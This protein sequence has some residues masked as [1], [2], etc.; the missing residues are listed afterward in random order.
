MNKLTF[1]IILIYCL[2]LCIS[3]I[4]IPETPMSKDNPNDIKALKEIQKETWLEE[5]FITDADVLY[6]SMRANGKPQI[7]Y[8]RYLCTTLYQHEAKTS[9]V[10]IIEYGT[11][12]APN[13]ESA[14]GVL[15]GE[16]YCPEWIK[17]FNKPRPKK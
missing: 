11:A 15:V 4:D 13:A 3:C 9:R 16:C 10:K 6:I 7:G 8:A 1:P 2:I 5:A 17:G 14:Y 12:N